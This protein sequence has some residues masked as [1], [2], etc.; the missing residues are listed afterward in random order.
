M[1]GTGG[2]GSSRERNGSLSGAGVSCR[3]Y[4]RFLRQNYGLREFGGSLADGSRI[5]SINNFV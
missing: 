2:T 1:T 5:N 3:K 4:S